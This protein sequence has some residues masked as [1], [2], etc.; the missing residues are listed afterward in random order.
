M[1]PTRTEA[2]PLP[3]NT[4]VRH[5]EDL[6]LDLVSR[7]AE[8]TLLIESIV[9]A[10][11]GHHPKFPEA[12]A[13]VSDLYNGLSEARADMD[14][15]DLIVRAVDDGSIAIEFHRPD[16]RFLASIEEQPQDSGW[17]LVSTPRLGS[18]FMTGVLSPPGIR[19]AARMIGLHQRRES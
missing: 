8:R 19:A 5:K 18:T 13:V 7:E 10:G 17:S 4:P 1:I 11:C 16:W 14:R 2:I 9:W 12:M 3:R 6:V 15:L